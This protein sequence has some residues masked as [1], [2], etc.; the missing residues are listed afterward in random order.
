MNFLQN[1]LLLLPFCLPC[2][3]ALA[4]V[5]NDMDSS[6]LITDDSQ[7]YV[8][9]QD[10]KDFESSEKAMY[11]F[12]YRSYIMPF[13]E[14]HAK[15]TGTIYARFT[16]EQKGKVSNPIILKGLTNFTDSELVRVLRTMPDWYR[17]TNDSKQLQ[18]PLQK[19]IRFDV[20]DSLFQC[21][22]SWYEKDQEMVYGKVSQM[23]QFPG[24]EDSLI[25]Y[26]SQNLRWPSTEA[27]CEG[28]VY[29]TFI[30]Q[31]DGSITNIQILRSLCPKYNEEALRVISLF[32]AWEPGKCHDI[33]VPVRIT[34][35]VR[36]SF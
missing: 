23:P 35:P 4:Q 26:I 16:I 34:L 33:A 21:S 13:N 19:T 9:F 14:H 25:Q 7:F 22:K 18:A 36:F 10:T 11:E 1:F 5:Y 24:G 6:I 27:P 28:T 30:V 8:F 17:D 2:N 32:P 15:T 20:A 3:T 12:L 29:I 31:P